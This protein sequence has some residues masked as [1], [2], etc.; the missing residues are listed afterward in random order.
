MDSDRIQLQH[1][2]KQS[3][4]VVANQI[5][6]GIINLWRSVAYV[7]CIQGYKVD[8]KMIIDKDSRKVAMRK[9]V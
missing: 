1:L 6:I 2:P 7:T 4:N 5:K 3:R 8:V 9:M